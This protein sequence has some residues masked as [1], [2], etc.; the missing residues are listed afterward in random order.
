MALNE[1]LHVQQ[2]KIK[3]KKTGMFLTNLETG[4]FLHGL[5]HIIKTAVSAISVRSGWSKTI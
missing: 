5:A 2:N 1:R 4:P 3:G